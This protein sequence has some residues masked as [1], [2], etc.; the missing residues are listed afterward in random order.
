MVTG[1]HSKQI[2]LRKVLKIMI[3][4]ETGTLKGRGTV[5]GAAECCF[6]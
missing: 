5:K 6:R 4:S 3:L 2:E 1:L